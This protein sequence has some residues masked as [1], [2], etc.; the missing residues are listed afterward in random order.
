[1]RRPANHPYKRGTDYRRVNAKYRSIFTK[2]AALRRHCRH[3][4]TVTQE[5]PAED[6]NGL[7][8]EGM[9]V[10]RCVDCH[11]LMNQKENA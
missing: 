9:T 3:Q 4:Q 2:D 1:M 10:V 11:Q 5:L 6:V 8:I 7:A